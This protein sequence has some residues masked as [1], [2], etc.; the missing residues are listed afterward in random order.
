MKSEKNLPKLDY[1]YFGFELSWLLFFFVQQKK[2][3]EKQV[4]NGV[5]S[6]KKKN[7]KKHK[8]KILC[9]LFP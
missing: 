6:L 5:F 9:V 8:N 7:K 4:S 2:K 1:Y 3:K